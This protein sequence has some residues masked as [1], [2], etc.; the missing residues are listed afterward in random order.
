MPK[1][2][3]DYTVDELLAHAKTTE[4]SHSLLQSLTANPETRE[5]IQR[6]IKKVNPKISI[7]EIDSR[8]TVLAAVATE[9]EER[10]KLERR[11]QEDEIRRRLETNRADIMARHKLS[12][13]DMLE[14]EKLMTRD[15]DPIPSYEGAALVYKASR[16]SAT[17]TPATY[18]PPTYEMPEKDI[19]GKGIGNRAAL[20]KIAINEA[21]GAWNE[22]MSG[23]VPGLGGAKLN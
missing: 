16:Q 2:L 7:P 19:W 5:M 1:S 8:D 14:V 11:I 20:D 6:A 17:P 13:D 10:L 4:S 23:K 18:M 22:I 21:F 12:K 15:T 9:R 3:E